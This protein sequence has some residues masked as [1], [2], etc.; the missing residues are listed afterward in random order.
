MDKF[1]CRGKTP[2]DE[3]Y[4]GEKWVVGYYTCF[5]DTEHRIYTGYAETDI[6][7]YYPDWFNV[8]P[9]TIGRYTEMEDK[10]DNR[11]FEG[12]IIYRDWFGGRNYIV[13]Y[14]NLL[15][16]FIGVTGDGCFTSF[17]GDS[18]FFIIIG[19]MYDNPELMD[20]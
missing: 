10:Y 15:G 5:N 18:N 8:I 1:L 7:D 14:D 3:N 4:N 19:N 9:E 11:I 2:I 13:T 6:G 17:E 12:D 20:N 16:R